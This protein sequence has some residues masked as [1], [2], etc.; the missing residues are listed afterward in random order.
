M[1]KGFKIA[2]TVAPFAALALLAAFVIY[3]IV[4]LAPKENMALVKKAAIDETMTLD[5]FLFRDETVLTA[6]GEV[7]QIVAKDGEK[8]AAGAVV[9]NDGED[10]IS[11]KSGFFYSDV[12][13]YETLLTAD[14]ALALDVGNFDKV[15][16][17]NPFD[18]S[19][20]AKPTRP[21]G[22]FGKVATDFCWYFA[23]KTARNDKF[24]VG[25]K[26]AADFGGAKV[27]LDLVKLSSDEKNSVLVFRC[28]ETP[29]GIELKRSMTAGITVA[30]H[31]GTA[32]PSKAVY[33]IDKSTYVYIFDDGYARRCA[34]N[35]IFEKDG[36][37]VIESKYVHEGDLVIIEKDLYDGKVMH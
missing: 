3:H 23:V 11:E 19:K 29:R 5:G 10:I 26:Y 4:S 32:V 37:C 9:A 36:V 33:H 14:A 18:D 8:I 7:R 21:V 31:T 34:V 27:T 25:E 16:T 17:K 28:D 1:K 35:L 15:T 2:V 22:A 13:G 12:D 6:S 20:H 30:V 24:K